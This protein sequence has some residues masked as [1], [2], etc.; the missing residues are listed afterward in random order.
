MTIK[1]CDDKSLLITKYEQIYQGEN[2]SGVLTFLI[3]ET[4]ADI[5]LG[6]CDLR[7]N[8]ID[9]NAK[10]HSTPLTKGEEK[11]RDYLVYRLS[12]TTWLTAI[13]GVLTL[14]IT[15]RDKLSKL[16]LKSGSTQ[17]TIKPSVEISDGPDA[18]NET[19]QKLE[20]LA[21]RVDAIEQ[22]QATGLR[23]DSYRLVLKN[24]DNEQIGEPVEIDP[25]VP[26]VL[27]D[28]DAVEPENPTKE[29]DLI[30]ATAEL[31][32]EVPVVSIDEEE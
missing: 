25:E 18:P 11:C 19:M 5:V 24:K 14:S 9:A 12:I 3:P 21:Q 31:D 2:N 13:A 30:G 1:M 16:I 7:L 15:F 26:V 32:S 28:D 6:D 4:Y 20:A 8:Y 10:Y 17:I 27:I 22:T 29:E 23:L